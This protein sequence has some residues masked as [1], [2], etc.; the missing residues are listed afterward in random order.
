[1]GI[2]NSVGYVNA[3]FKNIGLKNYTDVLS[4]KI[5]RRFFPEV[6][7]ESHFQLGDPIGDLATIRKEDFE[8]NVLPHVSKPEDRA[9]LAKVF[10]ATA[11]GYA[12][13]PRSPGRAKWTCRA[14]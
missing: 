1:M 9:Y 5:E 13:D 10:T 6:Y 14:P 2:F 12:L 4:G 8:K 7:R 3:D 11:Q